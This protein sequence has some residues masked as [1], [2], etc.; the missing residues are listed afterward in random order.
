MPTP[1]ALIPGWYGKIPALGD[2][3]S[4]RLPP[5][6]VS[7]WDRWL[8][9]GLAASRARLGAGWLQTYLT[10][11]I[12]RFAL[13]PGALDGT[14]WMGLMMPSV[15]K[16]GRHFPLTVATRPNGGIDALPALLRAE[17]WFARIE[18]AALATLDTACSAQ[19]FEDRLAALPF[20]ALPGAAGSEAARA[21]SKWL[22]T[23][24]D[25]LSVLIPDAPSLA[26]LMDGAGRSLLTRLSPGVSL[27]W[28][29]APSG[30][31]MLHA[32]RGLPPEERFA[33]LLQMTP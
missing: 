9:H 1:T 27:W 7:A 26:G 22:A 30:G 10:G 13:A 2:F 21:L 12:W 11:P 25:S 8:Q 5:E 32:F 17:P 29:A 15:D 24:G 19:Q 20:P 3:A 31:A 6:F 4:R 23:P 33:D 28:S 14:L 16:A 18:D